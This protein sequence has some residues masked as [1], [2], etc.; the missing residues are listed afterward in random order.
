MIV[1]EIKESSVQRDMDLVRQLL[2]R[3]ERDPQ[4]DGSRW[5][6]FDPADLGIEERSPEEIG[7]HMKLL[8]EAGYLNGKYAFEAI[9]IISKLTWEGHEFLDNIKDVGVWEKTKKRIDGLSGVALKVVAAIAESEI[10][11]HLGL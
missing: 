3:I 4:L 9:P 7:Y 10:K 5:V 2:L 8:I 6:H 11:K 1:Y